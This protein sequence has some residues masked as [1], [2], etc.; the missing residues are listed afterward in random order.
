MTADDFIK[1]V[2]AWAKPSLLDVEPRPE[3]PVDNARLRE[4]DRFERTVL[5]ARIPRTLLGR[6][7]GT[8][9]K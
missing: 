3:Y 1:R 2:N 8:R 9:R 6:T 5:A 4:W 7:P